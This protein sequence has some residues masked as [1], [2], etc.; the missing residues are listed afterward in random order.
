MIKRGER[1][2]RYLDHSNSPKCVLRDRP[3]FFKCDSV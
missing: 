3:L 1:E 2:Q